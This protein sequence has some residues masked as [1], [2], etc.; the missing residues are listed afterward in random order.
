MSNVRLLKLHILS[1]ASQLIKVLCYCL[2]T[3]TLAHVLTE[4]FAIH[5]DDT[6]ICSQKVFLISSLQQRTISCINSILYMEIECAPFS[7]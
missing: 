6:E 1:V 3:R 7:I 5:S 2:E 4:C